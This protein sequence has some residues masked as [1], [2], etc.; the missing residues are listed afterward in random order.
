MLRRQKMHLAFLLEFG[1]TWN[2][3]RKNDPVEQK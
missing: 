3:F 2:G 1:L